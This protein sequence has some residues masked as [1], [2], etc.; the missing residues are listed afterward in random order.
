MKKGGLAKLIFQT[1][2]EVEDY[3]HFASHVRNAVH[4]ADRSSWLQK[5][6]SK[7]WKNLTMTNINYASLGMETNVNT[8]AE[9]TILKNYIFRFE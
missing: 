4:T 1:I 7:Y 8:I 9:F 3:S 2:K 6:H 5:G